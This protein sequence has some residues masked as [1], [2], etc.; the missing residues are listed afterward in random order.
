MKATGGMIAASAL[1]IG[2]LNALAQAPA[3]AAAAA[4]AEVAKPAPTVTY[5]ADL[6]LREEYYN[7]IHADKTGKLF[8]YDE[9]NYFRVRPRAW[10]KW[11]AAKPVSIY[12]RIAN[13]FRYALEPDDH[14]TGVEGT[15][16]AIEKRNHAWKFADELVVDNLYIDLKNVCGGMF[17]A[18]IG[19]QDLMYGTG[20]L[21]LEGTPNDGS[22]TIYS[23]AVKISFK[24]IPK[25]TIDFF[26]IYNRPTNDLVLGNEDRALIGTVEKGGGVYL[27]NKALE[28]CP[29][30]TYYMFKNEDTAT[31]RNVNAV[32]FRVMPKVG[33]VKGN[34][35]VAYQFGDFG[36][37]DTSGAM[38]DALLSWE[39]YSTGMK[40]TLDVG[41]YYLS[42]D[43]PTT[44]DK[45]EG[46]N[47][48]WARYPQNSELYVFAYGGPGRWSNLGMPFIGASMQVAK[49]VKLKVRVADLTAPQ[50][51][52]PGTGHRRGLLGQVITEF[53]V[54]NKL[55]G[56][57]DKVTGHVL[58]DVLKEGDYYTTRD[59]EIFARWQLMYAF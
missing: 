7:N 20:K 16:A 17:D 29:F 22:R 2:T 59:T 53:T 48:L 47:P 23:D 24:G 58:A 45:D 38:V 12:L 37:V 33:P 1:L 26:G 28:A 3:P 42:G 34:L 41:C 19:R 8:G 51:D 43:D 13:E 35:E 52:G 10:I 6:R 18:R 11:D 5:G 14:E 44:A 21:V 46:W 56:K 31:N 40:P 25:N 27:M 54:C 39:L 55:F 9:N 30:E 4:P 50:D 36:D 15:D 57:N 49:D 32:G